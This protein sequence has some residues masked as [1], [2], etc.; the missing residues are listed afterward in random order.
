MNKM[1]ERWTDNSKFPRENPFDVPEGY[2]DVMEDRIEGRI[3]TAEGKRSLPGQK[4]I[5]MVKP[6][7]GLA[8]SFA[9][10]FLLIYYPI[11]KILP[12][13]SARQAGE[14]TEEIKLDEVLL[15]DYRYL[16]EGIFF[17]ALTSQEEPNE[18][19][20][21]EIISFLSSELDDY[22]VYSEIVN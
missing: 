3:R 20:S 2:F 5:L 15:T 6:I 7:L 13:Y 14:K 10:A 18:F 17:L 9:L 1:Q 12:W 11:S 16:D 21:D 19:E 8:A 4:L 22:E